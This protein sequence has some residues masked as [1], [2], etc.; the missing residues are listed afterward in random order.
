MLLVIYLIATRVDMIKFLL[1]A[2]ALTVLCGCAA[3]PNRI[4]SSGPVQHIVICWLKQPGNTQARKELIEVSRDL[5]S[6][7]GTVSVSA[8]EVLLSERPVVDDSFDV[9]IV[10]TFET[11][12]AMQAYL[13]HPQHKK[14]VEET[15]RP[16]VERFIVY[17]F[18]E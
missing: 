3:T 8:G 17:D 14:A 4:P 15:I 10:I 13:I 2:M 12:E 16:L 7:P 18:I 9:G 5:I 11:A 6:I 1:R